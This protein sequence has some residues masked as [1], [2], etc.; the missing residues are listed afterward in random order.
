MRWDKTTFIQ[1]HQAPGTRLS[2]A[3]LLVTA[4]IIAFVA[5]RAEART[6]P[7]VSEANVVAIFD[8]ANTADIETGSLGARKGANKEVRDYGTMLSQVHTEVRQKGRD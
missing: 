1:R 8:L 4:G 2:I 7:A 3:A 6:T 5:S